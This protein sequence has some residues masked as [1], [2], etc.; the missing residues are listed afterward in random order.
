[1]KLYFR[2][3]SLH[4][5]AQMQ[6]K[7]SFFLTFFGQILVSFSVFLTVYFMFQRFHTVDGFSFQEVLLCFA[8]VNLS[9]SIAETFARGF[10]LF[11][12]V[13]ANGEFDRMLVRPRG[14]IFQTMVC[15][16]DFTRFGKGGQALLVLAYAIP[17]CGVAWTVEKAILLLLMLMGQTALFTALF[18][19]YA[20]IC[21]F[22]LEGLEILNIFIYGGREFAAYPFVIYGTMVLRF[23]TFVIPFALVQY[24]P[25]L[26]LLGKSTTWWYGLLPV[27]AMLFLLPCWLVWRIG[28]RHYRSTGS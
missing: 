5:R 20:G 12:R 25:L 6:Y 22:T 2:Y 10:D 7:T 13:I 21:F 26:L 28:L 24:Y 11:H 23:A 15:K 4:L 14:M 16:M 1:M 3:F 8:T 19:L 27:V 17:A 18:V 9:F